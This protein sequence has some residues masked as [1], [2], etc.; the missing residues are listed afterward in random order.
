MVI[1]ILTSHW[2]LVQSVWSGTLTGQS[3]AFKRDSYNFQDC[4]LLYYI[5]KAAWHR[6]QHIFHSFKCSKCYFAWWLLIFVAIYHKFWHEL[7]FCF[8]TE[9]ACNM[10]VFKICCLGENLLF[11]CQCVHNFISCVSCVIR[12]AVN[13]VLIRWVFNGEYFC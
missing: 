10:I 12:F 1:D 5:Q 3:V 4:I 13:F 11:N 2:S 7:D 8:Y 6:G 9:L